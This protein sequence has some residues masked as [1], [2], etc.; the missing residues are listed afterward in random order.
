MSAKGRH[1]LNQKAWR[2]PF[3]F[4]NRAQAQILT[5]WG[6][7]AQIIGL[8][9]ATCDQRSRPRIFIFILVCD[10]RA[11]LFFCVATV[12]SWLADNGSP[13]HMSRS[14]KANQWLKSKKLKTK[15]SSFASARTAGIVRR[16]LYREALRLPSWHLV[17]RLT[18]A[19]YK[20]MISFSNQRRY[21]LS[22]QLT[23][24]ASSSN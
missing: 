15:N 4:L 22:Y 6:L 17:L 13:L 10:I 11:R 5:H 21:G 23:F 3:E 24:Y 16:V 2:A 19:R 7:K 18:V 20:I 14:K 8:V 9:W 12:L 1:D